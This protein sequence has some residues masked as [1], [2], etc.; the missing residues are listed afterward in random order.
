[1]RPP[2]AVPSGGRP[3]TVE[4]RHCREQRGENRAEGQSRMYDESHTRGVLDLHGPPPVRQPGY[5]R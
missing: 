5:L 2:A 1:M 4:A 3:S